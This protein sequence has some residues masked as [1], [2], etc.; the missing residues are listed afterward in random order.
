MGGWP[1]GV[2]GGE[3]DCMLWL[4]SGF[5]GIHASKACVGRGMLRGGGGDYM[6]WL[7]S[8]FMGIHASKACVGEGCGRC[9]QYRGL[10]HGW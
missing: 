2:G 9:G 3:R 10:V 1:V 7:M 4:M 8:G 5:M 6:L